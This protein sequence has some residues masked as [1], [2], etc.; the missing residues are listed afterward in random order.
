[1]RYSS[2]ILV[3]AL[4][5]ALSL[6]MTASPSSAAGL[7]ASTPQKTTSFN[8]TVNTV[9][10]S[11][12][13][14][15]VGGSF[16]EATDATG[17]VF[18]RRSAAAINAKTGRVMSWN[19]YTNGT[20]NA[21]AVKGR[22]V[23]LGGAFSRARG[24]ALHNVA[25]VAA[26]KYGRVF[27]AFKFRTSQPVHAM[28]R[29]GRFLYVGGDF[30]RMKGKS[31]VRL[32]AINLR[33]VRLA[34][35]TPSASG[36]VRVIKTSPKRVFVGGQ[37]MSLNGSAKTPNLGM[38]RREDGKRI[39]GFRSTIDRTRPVADIEVTRRRIY[40]GS[41]GT[42]GR[43][44]VLRRNTG[45]TLWARTFDGDVDSLAAMNRRI[46]IGGHF[47][48][49]CKTSRTGKA[50]VCLDGAVP[51]G[52]LAAYGIGGRLVPWSPMTDSAD[53]VL[54]LTKSTTLNELSAGGAF[55]K[56]HGGTI[57]QRAFA[58]FKAP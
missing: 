28:A 15:Y 42:G 1:M 17:K 10:Y 22:Y 46:Y 7:V 25:K 43:M 24:H 20:V 16:T 8:G 21:I 32:A 56:F 34:R 53:G 29:R 55:V 44:T 11:G 2:K 58:Q 54:A 35:W 3:S 18:S 51:R 12:S 48:N 19:P 31:R 4:A 57:K 26:A 23:Y 33:T 14:I 40:A 5:V 30:T 49:V 41:G 38:L 50:G 13:T 6:G 45:R 27:P 39:R 36:V 37:F 52:K 9:V 47:E